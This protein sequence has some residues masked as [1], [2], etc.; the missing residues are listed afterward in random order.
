MDMLPEDYRSVIVMRHLEGLSFGDVATR[1]ERS[2]GACRMLWLRA[3]E[4]I[5]ESLAADGWL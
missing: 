2:A 1:L 3:I 5:R 4:Q